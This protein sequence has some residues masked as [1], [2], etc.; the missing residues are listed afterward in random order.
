MVGHRFRK[1]L[2]KAPHSSLVVSAAVLLIA[3]VGTADRVAAA[4]VVT[5]TKYVVP[6]SLAQ[7]APRSLHVSGTLCALP[8]SLEGDDR[9]VHLLIPGGSYNASYWD[10]G[11]FNGIEYSYARA[12]AAAGIPTFNIDLLGT[13][14][15]SIPLSSE[16]TVDSQAFVTHQVVQVLRGAS[17]EVRPALPSFKKVVSVGH[18]RGTLTAWR[19][20]VAYQDVDGLV[21]TGMVHNVTLD[22]ITLLGTAFQP[23]VVDDKFLLQPL[24]P[25]WL[26]TRPGQREAVLYNP[27]AA[28]PD[29]IAHDEATKDIF[30]GLEAGGLFENTQKTTVALNIPILSIMGDHDFLCSPNAFGAA[31]SC[32]S[33]AQL[34]ASEAGSYGPRATITGC[35]LAGV[36]HNVALHR[37][38][39]IADQAAVAWSRT[40]VGQHGVK[41]T[42]SLPAA[43]RS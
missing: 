21:A 39:P 36:G 11:R 25:G 7:G 5:C 42:T 18:S 27:A 20:A 9:T 8:S 35:A 2:G 10:F 38:A 14:G 30:S 43:C 32:G 3:S 37:A 26:T 16:V 23:A 13:G 31:F 15:S 33:G 4:E 34:A 41:K 24:D 40:F 1:L 29:V 17:T 6:V 28:D 12:L 19:E 22:L